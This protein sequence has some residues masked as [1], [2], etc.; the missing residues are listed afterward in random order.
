MCLTKLRDK[1]ILSNIAY[2]VKSRSIGCTLLACLELPIIL[3]Y[4]AALL[5]LFKPTNNIYKLPTTVFVVL[6]SSTYL[7]TVGIEGLI[8]HLIT[9]KHTWQSVGII[10]TR[11]R[12]VAE[13]ST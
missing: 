6:P 10:W 2:G 5:S 9:L 3:I 1:P 11:D 4:F 12:R 7:F 8:F 13:T